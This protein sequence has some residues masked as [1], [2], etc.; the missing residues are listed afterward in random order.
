MI[1]ARGAN[2]QQDF[3]M[4]AAACRRAGRLKEE[5]VAQYCTGVL[6]DNAGQRL[7]AKECYTRMLAAAQACPDDAAARAARMV[8]HNRL[9]VNLQALGDPTGALAHHNAHLELADPPGKFVAHLNLGLT[10]TALGSLDEVRMDASTRGLGPA[11]PA[12]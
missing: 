1:G 8:A 5:A 9:G 11:R 3:Q 10:Q 7:K 6:F 12:C 2:T 4:L